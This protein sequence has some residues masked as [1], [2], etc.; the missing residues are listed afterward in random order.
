MENKIREIINRENYYDKYFKNNLDD[1]NILCSAMDV[2]GDT[3]LAIQ[4]F[5][6]QG[7]GQDKGEKYLRLYGLLQAVYLQQDATMSL[8]KIIKRLFDTQ[9]N[10][11]DW[12]KFSVEK[13][14]LLR[15]YRNL[16]VGHPIECKTFDKGATKRSFISRTS[17]SSDGFHVLVWDKVQNTKDRFEQVDLSALLKAYKLE[18]QSILLSIEKFLEKGLIDPTFANRI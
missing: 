1:W 17:L 14:E 3:T 5:L 6:D 8:Y 12:E 13:W 10:L 16:S 18:A 15:R 2:I 11:K 4:D 7:I 9:N